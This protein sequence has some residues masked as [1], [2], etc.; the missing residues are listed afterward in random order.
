MQTLLIVEDEKLI[1]KGIATMAARCCVHIDEIIESRNGAEALEILKARRIDT[2]F[3]DIRM[4]KMD[5][6]E[7]IR[8]IDELEEKPD[9]VVLS[10]YDDF[11]YAVEMLKH[12]VF[13]YVLKPVKRETIE[14][15]LVKLEAKQ[16]KNAV[17]VKK[18]IQLLYHQIKFM[19]SSNMSA[20]EIENAQKQYRD[21][22]DDS[23]YVIA[24]VPQGGN[25]SENDFFGVLL[26]NI[27]GQDI[28]LMPEELYLTWK[29]KTSSRCFGVSCF[30][31]SFSECSMA[32]QE[33]LRAR[34]EAF[35]RCQTC[36][37]AGDVRTYEPSEDETKEA[38]QFVEQF[39]RQLST[40]EW[41]DALKRLE[42]M[43]F[44][45]CHGKRP[46][47][48]VLNI[49]E[50]IEKMVVEVYQSVVPE[51]KKEILRLESP[52]SC[53]D[54]S[55]FISKLKSWMLSFVNCL[56]DEYL[57]DQNK[58][59]IRA[60]L[61]YIH[62]NYQKDLNMAQVSN[63]VCMNYSLFSLTFKEY[64]GVNFVNYLKNIRIKEAKRLLAETDWKVA[65]IGHKVG[66][67]NDKHF[68]KIFKNI[69]GISPSDYRKNLL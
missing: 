32:Y 47:G 68:M 50:N 54:S 23:P 65:D 41:E 43:F 60:A 59:K 69:C 21:I 25:F 5:G 13:D 22:Y 34:I 55:E 52:L 2:V 53:V 48:Q 42:S 28:L 33:A 4:P 44:E 29:T 45:A 51:H 57:Y 35:M 19:L 6:L 63:Y 20:D 12:G 58:R 38:E 11:N 17:K 30:H 66:Y 36:V 15:L 56:S 62:E 24:C 46:A 1:R 31:S 27:K 26:E 61:E 18:E 3:M 10:G 8:H 67:E 64:T 40:K 9:V 37:Q 16:Q 39:V 7:L 49:A 14:D